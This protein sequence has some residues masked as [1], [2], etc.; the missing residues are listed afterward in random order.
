VIHETIINIYGTVVRQ[1]QE[2]VKQFIVPAILDHDE[3]ER[4]RSR[5]N[6]NTRENYFKKNVAT[7]IRFSGK[8]YRTMS[9]DITP[10]ESK[11]NAEPSSLVHQLESYYKQ[12][13]YFGLEECYIE[14]IF[15]Q[16]MYYICAVSLNSLMLRQDMCTWKTGMKIRYN[17]S[18]LEDWIRRKKLV[19]VNV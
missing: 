6:S 4:G 13:T 9:L 14:Q 19:N 17:V 10:E 7:L 2:L 18:C 12:C 15:K 11:P 5:G 3:M 8:S 1:V 16:L